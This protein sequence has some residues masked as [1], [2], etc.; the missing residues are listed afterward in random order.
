MKFYD[1]K[2]LYLRKL[3]CALRE[4]SI[5]VNGILIPILLY[6]VL[7]WLLYTGFTFVS[8]QNDDLKSRLMLR[9]IS[10]AH[11]TLRKALVEDQLIELKTSN[12][13]LSDIQSGALDALVEFVPPKA[14][15]ERNLE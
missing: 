10:A 11:E 8:G 6:P 5:V 1:I 13:P 4:R 2:I 14:G 3:R 12:D 9:N 7:I 15:S